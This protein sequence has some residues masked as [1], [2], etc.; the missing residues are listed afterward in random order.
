M[1]LMT[2]ASSF[3]GVRLEGVHC[4]QRHLYVLLKRWYTLLLLGHTHP[5]EAHQVRPYYPA[6]TLTS[7]YPQ[8]I[9]GPVKCET[10]GCGLLRATLDPTLSLYERTPSNMYVSNAIH[11]ITVCS[12]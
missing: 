11:C 5:H 1:S 6:T 8:T 10:W 7:D 12:P 4:I 2:G 3:Q 9:K